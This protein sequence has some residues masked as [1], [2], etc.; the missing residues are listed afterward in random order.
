MCL[1]ILR[2]IIESHKEDRL[3]IQGDFNATPVS[4]RFNEMCDMIH[5]NNV[6]R[7]MDILPDDTY[8]H[9]NNGSQTCS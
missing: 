9:V 5:E 4:P 1:C 2:S 6:F 3:C 8:T 7:D